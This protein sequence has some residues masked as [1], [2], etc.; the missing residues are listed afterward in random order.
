M[1]LLPVS[2]LVLGVHAHAGTFTDALGRK[3]DLPDSP[4][5]IVSLAPHLTEILFAIGAGDSVVGVTS[6]CDYPEAARRVPRI[7]GFSDPSIE[8][9]LAARPDVVIA[10]LVGNR[11]ESVEELIR[12]GLP[13]YVS[14]AEAIGEIPREVRRIGAV[15]GRAEGAESAARRM[16]G[17][18][19]EIARRTAGRR[20]VAVYY[21][22]WDQP[23]MTVSDGSFIHDAIRLAGG[24]NV[25]AGLSVANP[26]VSL[27]AVA[28]AKP[29]VMILSGM[30]KEG[31]GLASRWSRFAMIP[32]VAGGRIHIMNS[33]LLHRPGP[34]V[35]EGVEQL[36]RWIHP[37][38]FSERPGR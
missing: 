23:L 28:A 7:G 8:L 13:V 19:A 31:A 4:R 11:R 17:A 5:R 9:V 32:A 10:T 29:E 26:R 25:F 12:L 38:A 30:G 2:F 24:R 33:D 27:E 21:Q 18:L 20:R 22:L 6:F 16:E 15:A 34:R 1:L 37:D 3:V 36:S 14:G 35:I